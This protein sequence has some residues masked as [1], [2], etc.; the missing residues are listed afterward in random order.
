MTDMVVKQSQNN[1]IA[2]LGSGHSV[3]GQSQA[4]IPVGGRIRSGIMIL[5]AAGAKMPEA[6]K[7]YK[8]GVAAGKS[9]KQIGQDL[10]KVTDKIILR[11][12]NAPYFTVRQDDFSVPHAAQFIIDNFADTGPS[13]Q[14]VYRFPVIFPVDNWQAVMP[15][16]FACFTAGEKKYWSEYDADGNRL[17]MTRQ[18]VP[19]TNGKAQRLSGGRQAIQR[20]DNGGICNPDECPEYQSQPQKCKLSG[21][22][23][24]FIPGLHGAKAVD[25]PT[26]SIYSLMEARQQLEMVS[27]I[28][29]GKISGTHNG[30]ALFYISKKE[31]AVSM[32]DPKTGKPKRVKQFLISLDANIDMTQM[33]HQNEDQNLLASGGQA[34][35]ALGHEQ[36]PTDDDHMYEDPADGEFIPAD[37]VVEEDT[38]PTPAPS[39]VEAKPEPA[40]GAPDI[41]EELLLNKI[42]GASTQDDLSVV[43]DL[44][45][46]LPDK[47]AVKRVQK[48]MSEMYKHLGGGA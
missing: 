42:E 2:N 29:G 13:G 7:I 36:G 20:K 39:N 47:E 43:A 17:C 48:A 21:R 8:E 19:V 41:S 26:N 27:F 6:V 38:N 22:F 15:H 4:S 31:K 37:V 30:K 45:S 34:A 16:E 1:S 28:T 25:L 44:L 5:T 40:N 14:Q 23:I 10:K 3:L 33:Y 32:I 24:F 9:F 11:P 46:E 12:S 18:T 35:A